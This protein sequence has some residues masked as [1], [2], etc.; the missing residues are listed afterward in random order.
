[1]CTAPPLQTQQGTNCR[2][3]GWAMGQAGPKSIGYFQSGGETLHHVSRP[4]TRSCPTFD[5]I[6]SVPIESQGGFSEMT[7]GEEPAP[8][9][10]LAGDP[11]RH[12]GLGTQLPAPSRAWD[13]SR[14]GPLGGS[15][16]QLMTQ[17]G[18]FLQLQG[19][20]KSKGTRFSTKTSW[21]AE[22]EGWVGDRETSLRAH[23]CASE[24]LLLEEPGCVPQLMPGARTA[25][26]QAPG[27]ATPPAHQRV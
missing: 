17:T 21:E 11:A 27:G 16:G 9:G 8:S 20:A 12:E 4:D 25:E 13:L 7:V 6:P 5:P 22:G 23:S 10:R 1:M 14:Q 18:S 15:M 24:T 26:A 19:V 3:E 2:C